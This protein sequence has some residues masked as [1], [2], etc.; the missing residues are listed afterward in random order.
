MTS[1]YKNYPA[2]ADFP[3]LS[4]HNNI[5]AK[6]LT[7]EVKKYNKI[8]YNSYYFFLRKCIIFMWRIK[9]QINDI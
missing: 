4:Q 9:K 8:I 6:C 1:R 2:E 7:T 5:M 3:D